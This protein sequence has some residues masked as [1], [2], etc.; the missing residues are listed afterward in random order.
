MGM[1]VS[2]VYVFNK[3]LLSAYRTILG[4]RDTAVVKMDE[5]GTPHEACVP[6]DRGGGR[7]H[8]VI[9]YVKSALDGEK[10]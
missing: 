6:W 10:R 3:Y 9:H 5:V 4:A 2:P 1:P 8:T 7:G